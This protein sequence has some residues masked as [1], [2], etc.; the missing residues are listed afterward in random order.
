MLYV[1]VVVLT[2][3]WPQINVIM[4]VPLWNVDCAVLLYLYTN[5]TC[6]LVELYVTSQLAVSANAN[7]ALSELRMQTD[8]GLLVHFLGC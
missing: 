5:W 2:K 3:C 8:V 1:I 4:T 7:I 6:R